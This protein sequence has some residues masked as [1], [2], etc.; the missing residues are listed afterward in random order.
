[1][2]FFVKPGSSKPGAFN[3][4]GEAPKDRILKKEFKAR[5]F[6]NRQESWKKYLDVF[7]L[8]HKNIPPRTTHDVALKASIP[9][10]KQV[11]VLNSRLS[12]RMRPKNNKNRV[13]NT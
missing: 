1:V 9:E 7:G 11:L 12:K 6:L 4:Y 2:E 8:V 3:R 13:R 10:K 5:G